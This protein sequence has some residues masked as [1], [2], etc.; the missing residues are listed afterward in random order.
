METK[1]IYY[2][3]KIIKQ[4]NSACI[5]IPSGVLNYLDLDVGDV[6]S[7]SIKRPE[8]INLPKDLLDI[9]RKHMRSI[10]KFTDK[11]MSLCFHYF[12]L[13]GNLLGNI[14]KNMSEKAKEIFER[15]I[16][17]DK[18][19][20]FLKRYQAFKRVMINLKNQ[21]KVIK[22]FEKTKYGPNFKKGLE[23]SG[24]YDIFF[25]K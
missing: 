25:P 9:Y 10:S 13:E 19:N 2:S 18:G 22:A 17:V 5:R 1:N 12:Q 3:T 20:K 24:A 8:I 4:G 16:A 6:A 21:K 11:E 14:D 7:I 23:I 15:A